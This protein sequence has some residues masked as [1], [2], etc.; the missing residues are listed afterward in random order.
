MPSFIPKRFSGR[1]V[2]DSYQS[3]RS[4]LGIFRNLDADNSL[5]LPT[6]KL[7]RFHF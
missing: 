7:L 5:V 1:Y 4:D 2:V 6:N 3:Q